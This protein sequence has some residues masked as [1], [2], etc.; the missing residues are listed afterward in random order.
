MATSGLRVGLRLADHWRARQATW[1]GV[2]EHVKLRR[3]RVHWYGQSRKC[4]IPSVI[5]VTQ[6]LLTF[7]RLLVLFN[8]IFLVLILLYRY[9]YS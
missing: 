6:L 5:L 4:Y 7:H 2:A 3:W 8:C 1:P 9:E